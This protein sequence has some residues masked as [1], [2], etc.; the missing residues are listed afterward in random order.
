METPKR[1]LRGQRQPFQAGKELAVFSNWISQ[2]A[3]DI[4]YHL[5][6]KRKPAK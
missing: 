6:Q 3:R 4:S 5:L 2:P 1:P